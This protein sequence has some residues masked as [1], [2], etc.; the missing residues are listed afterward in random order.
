MLGTLG[1]FSPACSCPAQRVPAPSHPP[2]LAP[3]THRGS[4]FR[5]T[6]AS[7]EVEPEASSSP[8]RTGPAPHS[9]L[10]PEPLL[11]PALPSFTVSRSLLQVL[12]APQLHSRP[13]SSLSPERPQP[14]PRTRAPGAAGSA[15]GEQKCRGQQG[16][17]DG[18]A[19]LVGGTRPLGAGSVRADRPR[20]LSSGHPAW[21]MAVVTR[22]VDS[23]ELNKRCHG[24]QGENPETLGVDSRRRYLKQARCLRGPSAPGGLPRRQGESLVSPGSGTP[25]TAGPDENDQRAAQAMGAAGRFRVDGAGAP[26][27]SECCSTGDRPGTAGAARWAA[28]PGPDSAPTRGRA[29][30]AVGTEVGAPCPRWLSSRQLCCLVF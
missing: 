8:L 3:R 25:A 12:L 10:W 14:P 22:R 15:R 6:L 28:G 11:P 23:K 1:S 16:G 18:A 19:T 13:R 30:H 21:P 24:L 5:A 2:T 9:Q 20:A 17:R 4:G 27:C 29:G 26:P 7:Q